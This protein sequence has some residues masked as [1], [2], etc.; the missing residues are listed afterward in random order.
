[1]K[2]SPLMASSLMLLRF[3]ASTQR[4]AYWKVDADVAANRYVSTLQ[5]TE[6]PNT[7]AAECVRVE[8]IPSGLE[9]ALDGTLLYTLGPTLIHATTTGD[10]K[11]LRT[12]TGSIR[13]FSLASQ[14]GD[15]AFHVHT[16]PAETIGWVF[17]NLP[18]KRD[19][20]G[21]LTGQDILWCTR[22]GDTQPLDLPGGFLPKISSDGESLLALIPTSH[23][24]DLLDSSLIL[25]SLDSNRRI[26]IPAPRSIITMEWAPDSKQFAVIARAGSIGTPV[27]AT[28]YVGSVNNPTLRALYTPALGWLGA[29]G[30]DADWRQSNAPP[31]LQWIDSTHILVGESRYATTR[32]VSVSLA[33]DV[34]EISRDDADYT[35]GVVGLSHIFAIRHDFSQFDEVVSLSE[36]EVSTLSAVNSERFP[37]PQEF[38]VQ[39]AHQ[40]LVQAFML[41][42]KGTYRGTILSIHGG[43]YNSFT[44]Q[45]TVLF[46]QLAASGFDVV[47]AN[48][49]GSVGYGESFTRALAGQWGVLDE[50]DWQCIVQD[51]T[52]RSRPALRL[53]VMGTSYGGFMAAWLAGHWPEIGAAVI[54]APIVNQL[55]MLWSSDIGYTFT[56]EG[57]AISWDEPDHAA[58]A[59]WNNSPLRYAHNIRCP[60]LLLHGQEDQRCPLSQS[61]ELYTLLKVNNIPSQLVIYPGESHLMTAQGSPRMRLDRFNRIAN[62][63]DTYL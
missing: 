5:V 63:F 61:E 14:T 2:L 18:L 58:D 60:V 21:Y 19:G 9:F 47:W 27:P 42:A 52:R 45:P 62:W 6:L 54:Q 3:H 40:D 29:D 25:V 26:G 12:F 1:M 28:L 53:G 16:P 44:H 10:M 17:D 50:Q 35:E 23:V 43:P 36:Q 46:H 20:R 59:L 37:P 51:I 38:W 31:S 55:D 32:L 11:P 34:K 57:C 24:Q 13:S 15:L 22:H 39:A 30:A 48:P 8:G 56:M 4:L 33:G 49:H 7:H 41:A